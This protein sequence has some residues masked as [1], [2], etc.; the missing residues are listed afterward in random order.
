MRMS[1]ELGLNMHLPFTEGFFFLI[2]ENYG[3]STIIGPLLSKKEDPE[4]VA[5]NLSSYNRQ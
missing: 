2:S 1:N 3:T 5:V 4:E